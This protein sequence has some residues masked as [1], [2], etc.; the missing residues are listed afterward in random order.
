MP[1]GEFQRI[2]RDLFQFGESIVISSTKE[3][4]KFCTVGDI[5]TGKVKIAV[6]LTWYHVNIFLEIS[7]AWLS[8]TKFW[9]N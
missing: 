6:K 4:I 9:K 3:G 1:S 8:Q 2:C 7:E 5:G